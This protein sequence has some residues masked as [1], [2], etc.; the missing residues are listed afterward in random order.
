MDNNDNHRHVTA[1]VAIMTIANYEFLESFLDSIQNNPQFLDIDDAA[2]SQELEKIIKQ[3]LTLLKDKTNHMREVL[4]QMG[5]SFS[6]EVIAARN[7]D[8][9]PQARPSNN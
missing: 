6:L 8:P 5:R 3:G 9:G 7:L 1:A 2:V 4:Q